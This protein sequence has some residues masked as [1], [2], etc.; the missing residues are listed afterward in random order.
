MMAP[1]RMQSDSSA[2][3]DA[4][5]L[6]LAS[7]STMGMGVSPYPCGQGVSPALAYGPRIRM[8]PPCRAVACALVY[9]FIFRDS[10]KK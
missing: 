1:I 2:F 4:R 9:A 8:R 7:W 10:K 6:A 5:A 3:T